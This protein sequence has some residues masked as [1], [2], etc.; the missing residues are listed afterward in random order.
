M[1]KPHDDERVRAAVR[2][3]V[4]EILDE[5]LLGHAESLKE[6][7]EECGDV[8]EQAVAKDE[9]RQIITLIRSAS[10]LTRLRTIA[11]AAIIWRATPCSD[12]PFCERG[13]HELA[14]KV[15]QSEIDLVAAI[16]AGKDTT[17]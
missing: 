14:C 17:P 6:V 3:A 11:E 13:D 4:I 9:I 7:W 2:R 1:I 12:L 8:N 15:M 5:D 16:D 10:D